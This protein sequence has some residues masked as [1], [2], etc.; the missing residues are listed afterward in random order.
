MIK[1]RKEQKGRWVLLEDLVA[2]V[3]KES[4]VRLDKQEQLE[5]LVLLDH[6]VL[7]ERLEV[8]VRLDSKVY[9]E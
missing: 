9:K 2:Q 5:L 3:L 1:G 6:L 4:V 8:L 7:E